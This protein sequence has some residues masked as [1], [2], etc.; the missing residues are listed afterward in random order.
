MS[1]P[2]DKPGSEAPHFHLRQT[3]VVRVKEGT[4]GYFVGHQTHVQAAEAGQQVVIRPGARL[5]PLR[6]DVGGSSAC[7]TGGC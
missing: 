2:A 7:L 3:E 5:D 6:E 1:T 4:L